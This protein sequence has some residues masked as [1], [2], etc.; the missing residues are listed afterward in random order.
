MTLAKLHRIDPAAVGLSSFGRAT[1]FYNRQIK[2][3]M[4]LGESYAS[5]VDVETQEAIGKLPSMEFLLEFFGTESSQPRDRTSI[6]HGDYKIDNIVWH[7][8]EPRII[9]ILDWEISTIGHPLSD[10]SN[11]LTPYT[12]TQLAEEGCKTHVHP[13]FSID[14]PLQGLPTK[15][16]CVAWYGEVAGWDAA[17]EM[18]WADGFCIFRTAV[19]LMGIAARYAIRQTRGEEAYE[20]GLDRIHYA[21]TAQRIVASLQE[22][23]AKL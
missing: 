11:M 19:M 14:T 16:Q 4:S 17:K 15:D 18:L 20:I 9:G 2:T 23:K 21:R 6:T 7:K 10:L 12:I 5:I 3:L 1:G 8:T 13:A 22:N